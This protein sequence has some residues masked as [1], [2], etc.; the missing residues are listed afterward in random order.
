VDRLYLSR[1]VELARR[2]LGDTS[3]NPPVGAV[4]VRD[5][6]VLGEGFHHRAGDQHAETEALRAAGDVRGATMYVSL[7]PC[8]HVG[9]TPACAPAL[10]DAGIA[11]V[12]IGVEDP[13]PKTAGGGIAR[14]RAAGIA[15]EVAHDAGAQATIDI[16]TR[17]IRMERPYLALKLAMSLDGY[18]TSKPGVQ[19]WLTGEE[20]RAYVRELRIAHDAV[21]VGAGTVRVDDAQLTVRPAHARRQPYRRIVV[22]ERDIVDPSSRIFDEVE[23]YDRSIVLAPSGMRAA[24]APLEARADVTY[25]GNASATTLDLVG[26]LRALRERGIFSILCEG[27]PTLGA[28]LIAQGLVD[29]VYWAIAP[30]L[31]ANPQAVPVLAG[32]DLATLGRELRFERSERVGDDV[33]VTGVFTDV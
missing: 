23:G 2:A 27:G 21:M 29:R 28:R 25:V 15:V 12:V 5:G 26:A 7:E 6:R 9:R 3:P 16:F 11:R 33:I 22:C 24:F 4:I 31:L 32:T 30:R 20:E 18:I 1:A 14:L 13:N 19:E 10:V 17:A 8:N